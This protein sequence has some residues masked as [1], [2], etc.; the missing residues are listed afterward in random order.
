VPQVS[1]DIAGHFRSGD[2]QLALQFDARYRVEQV[3]SAIRTLAGE[4]ASR[5][6][7]KEIAYSLD[8]RPSEVCR[9]L[10][11]TDNREMGLRLLVFLA[12]SE[13][14][15][16]IAQVLAQACGLEARPAEKIS[17]REYRQRMEVALASVPEG[18]AAEL[19]KKA[20]V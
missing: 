19:R 8:M 14:D 3:A 12:L 17:D 13:P 16:S 5:R 1:P 18:F 6:G 15:H 11:E 20:G 2:V 9:D 7:V 10:H 4:E